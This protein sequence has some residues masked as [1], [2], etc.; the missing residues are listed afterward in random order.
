MTPDAPLAGFELPPDVSQVESEN[1]LAVLAPETNAKSTGIMHDQVDQENSAQD[2]EPPKSKLVELLK[3]FEQPVDSERLP[4]KPV[5]ADSKHPKMFKKI[6][7]P[8]QT[9]TLAEHKENEDNAESVVIEI[10]VGS[11]DPSNLE[12]FEQ[13]K[14]IE[15]SDES[16]SSESGEGSDSG[17]SAQS[18]ESGQPGESGQSGQSDQSSQSTESC[19]SVESDKP[20]E[21]TE[22][23]EAK[24]PGEFNRPNEIQSSNPV[25]EELDEMTRNEEEHHL[26][27][28]R[29]FSPG[30][31]YERACEHESPSSEQTD[32][33]SEPDCLD[34]SV[35][36]CLPSVE[37][38][39]I[40]APNLIRGYNVGIDCLPMQR[41][42]MV[43]R[44]GVH[45]TMMVAGKS[46]LGKS[47]FVNT[48]FDT[49]ILP[50]IWQIGEDLSQETRCLIKYGAHFEAE[51]ANMHLNVIDTPG[52][53]SK[54]N[55]TFD[56]VPLVNY[57]DEQIRSYI[58]QEEQPNRGNIKDHR[59]HCCLYFLEPTNKGL[60]ALDVVAMKE[61]SKRVNMI[62]VIAK[63]DA[64]SHDEMQSFKQEIREILHS[65]GIKVCQFLEESNSFYRDI[66]QVAPFGVVG[67][68][69]KVLDSNGQTIHVRKYRWGIVEVENPAHCDFSLLK[70][71][72]IL[73]HMA[74]LVRTTEEYYESCRASILKTRILK[75]RD[76]ASEGCLL[77]E[78]RRA[79]QELDYEQAD[80]NGL[81]NYA[82]YEAFNKKEM[83]SLVTECSP[84]F[85]QKRLE[86]RKKFNEVI[87][88][89]DQKFQEWKKAL[90]N[91]QLKFNQEIELLNQS[92]E[93]LQLECH[94]LESQIMT[95]KA[96]QRTRTKLSNISGTISKGDKRASS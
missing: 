31:D 60:C 23:T 75:A 87:N 89:E 32:V 71:V 44:D 72:L 57:I 49:C 14:R 4:K 93:D 59:V 54:C 85:V 63:A 40:E 83:D 21:F 3:A 12:N 62:P 96:V 90:Q 36:A 56:W 78:E 55:N 38:L 19:A 34:D 5:D 76:L 48:L 92:I 91:K 79:L 50:T 10:E 61:I 46:G 16:G 52:F 68:D 11:D 24:D 95:T 2:P 77:E 66:F 33:S 7:I 51:N 29:H 45:F 47:T 20:A 82:C 6:G 17:D 26:V 80:N 65:Q 13:S 64:L 15:Q 25:A 70:D 30:S 9:E 37:T 58:F 94:E 18:V 41:E 39:V 69:M 22:I 35:G 74:D 73:N 86:A 43:A 28:N 8:E 27:A 81:K 88:L 42:R 53:G 84:E 1:P 67:S